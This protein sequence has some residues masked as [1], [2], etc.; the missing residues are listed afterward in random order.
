[1]STEVRSYVLIGTL[2]SYADVQQWLGDDSFEQ[3]EPLIEKADAG[4]VGAFVCVYDGMNGNY[5]ALGQLIA[6]G[7]NDGGY[8]HLAAPVTIDGGDGA[9]IA[10]QIRNAI[11]KIGPFKVQPIVIAHWH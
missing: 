6:A 11:P 8:G 10:A 3:L 2:L 1:M 9:A 5:V 4:E 7:D